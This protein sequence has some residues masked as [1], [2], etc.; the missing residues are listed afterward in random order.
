MSRLTTVSKI[1]RRLEADE[2]DQ[3]SCSNQAGRRTGYG[4]DSWL[5]A[6]CNRGTTGSHGGDRGSASGRASA[7]RWPGCSVASSFSKSLCC[8]VDLEFDML[9]GLIAG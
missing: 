9:I 5:K 6:K 3:Q 2:V 7:P 8:I 4:A 1:Y